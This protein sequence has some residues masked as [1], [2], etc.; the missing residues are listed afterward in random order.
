MAKLSLSPCQSGGQ[1]WPAY[2]APGV[3][4]GRLVLAQGWQI[5][6][7]TGSHI[8]QNHLVSLLSILGTFFNAQS[9]VKYRSKINTLGTTLKQWGMGIGG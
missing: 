5:A 2:G 8:K 6:P 9:P 1:I 4:S 3:I 7:C